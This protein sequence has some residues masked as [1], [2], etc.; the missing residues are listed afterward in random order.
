MGARGKGEKAVPGSSDPVVPGDACSAW[1]CLAQCLAVPEEAWRC[2][3]TTRHRAR[4]RQEPPGTTGSEEPGT[5]FSPLVQT[6]EVEI[7]HF[8]GYFLPIEVLRLRLMK[9]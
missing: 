4:H 5:A 3:G 8:A 2:L 1:Q 7:S 9:F 6:L